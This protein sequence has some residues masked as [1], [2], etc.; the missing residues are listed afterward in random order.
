MPIPCEPA[1]SSYGRV[2]RH[3]C[4]VN[5]APLRRPALWGVSSCEG[6]LSPA[7]RSRGPL[8][9]LARH[10]HVDELW[11]SVTSRDRLKPKKR[12]STTRAFS[13]PALLQSRV[14]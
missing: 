3:P 10:G 11:Q 13:K 2:A 9:W 1:R 12:L 7:M 6:D 14:E 4:R 8:L 5:F